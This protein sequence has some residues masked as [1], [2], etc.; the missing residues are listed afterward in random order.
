MS[1]MKK[2][3]WV[4]SE[5]PPQV[6]V[7]AI[8]NVKFLKYLPQFN[9]GAVVICPKETAKHDETSEKLLRQ[10]SASITILASVSNPFRSLENKKIHLAYL[11][12]NMMP[13][14]GH[15]LWV[16][17][18]LFNIGPKIVEHK[19]HLVYTTCSPFSLN[20]IGAWVK[21]K[22]QLPWVTDFRDLW[23]LNPLLKRLMT[24]YY[25]LLSEVLERF[26]LKY[27][28]ALIVN[29]KNSQIRMIEKYPWL[30]NKIW[31][32][33]NGFDP[34]DIQVNNE[35]R[36]IPNSFFYGGSIYNKYSPLPLLQLLSKFLNKTY[37][38]SSWELH[39]AGNANDMFA[40]LV[41]Q[42]GIRVKCE[43]H[44]YLDPTS[45][46][47]FIQQMKFV[48]FCMPNNL[49]AKS[50]IPARL[51]DYIGNKSRIISLI[52]R[53]SEVANILE[54]YGNCL[55]IFYDEPIDIQCNKLHQYFTEL[56]HEKQVNKKII[57]G[58]SR[59][60]LTSQLAQIFDQL[61]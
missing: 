8:R 38:D 48:L 4:T 12:N 54:Q 21:Y 44:G 61:T 18:V 22:Y 32:I 16:F 9:W 60:L 45:Y 39:Y 5:F 58:F 33:P 31:V 43:T 53:D 27:C 30:N 57:D 15:N 6:N 46:N 3:L 13:P 55:T 49:D 26:Y 7:A 59:K 40:N 1:V 50:W 25:R 35:S 11:I 2:V 19:P 52:S 36:V 17:P 29:T 20:L 23:T 42:A 47:Q 37:S 34:E 28:D 41:R 51:Y 56:E 14:D 10:L 24:P